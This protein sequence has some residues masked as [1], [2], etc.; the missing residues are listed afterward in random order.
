[1][2]RTMATSH[3]GL[4]FAAIL[5]V[6]L[7][8][9]TGLGSDG[10]ATKRVF[11]LNSYHAGFPWTNGI[12]KGIRSVLGEADEA[13]EV[14]VEYMD[15]KRYAPET[16]YP[17]LGEFY[18]RKYA[19]QHFDVIIT[20]DDNA[21][22]FLLERRKD[23]F[24]GVPVVFCAIN[25]PD[26]P[27]IASQPDITGV[28]EDWDA[29]GTIKVARRL[30]P[31]LKRFF[32]VSDITPT[33]R[34]HL[35]CLRRIEPEYKGSLK[36]VELAELSEADLREALSR[37]PDDSAVLLLSFYRDR[38][39][40]AF[41]IEE[42]VSLVAGSSP[43]PVYTMW[44]I[45]VCGGVLGGIVTSGRAQG[46]AAGRMAL[47][48]L[49]GTKADGIP[50]LRSSPNVP[51]FDYAAMRRFGIAQSVL[52]PGSVII[53]KPFSFY[54][55]YNRLVWGVLG[56]FTVLVVFILV[57]MLNIAKR[58]R[59]ETALRKSENRLRTVFE[60]AET[61]AFITTDLEAPHYHITDFS[62][63]AERIFGYSRDEIVGREMALLHLGEDVAR[64]PKTIEA[65]RE[66]AT[67][68]SGETTLVRKS[69]EKFPAFLTV[70]PV[71]ND[72]GEMTGIL[73]VSI[74]ITERK[75][76]EAER[77]ALKAQ[78]RY[79]QKLESLGVM[80]GGIA[81]DFNNFLTGILCNA[82]LALGNIPDSSPVRTYVQEVKK[83][84]IRASQL[85]GEMLAYS[86]KGSFDLRP[87]DLNNLV[88]EMGHLLEVSIS[89]RVVL[90]Y[91]LA[92]DL[93]A[94]LAD[95][96]QIRQV[97]MNLITNAAEAICEGIGTVTIRTGVTFVD[98]QPLSSYYTKEPLPKGNY[99][100]LEVSDNGCGMSA[101]TLERLFDPFY[102]T[103]F[104][105]RGLGLAAVLGIVRGHHGAITVESELAKG[106]TFRVLLPIGDAPATLQVPG[107]DAGSNWRGSGKVL[108]ADDEELVR[109]VATAMLEHM[110]FEVLTASN[111]AEA[112]E[113]CT[114]HG[115]E[116]SLILLDMTMPRMNGEEVFKRIR[117]VRSDLKV[118][119]TSGYTEQAAADRFTG[120]APAGFIHKPFDLKELRE[121][122]RE[123]LAS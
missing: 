44:D 109:N 20:S 16:V 80:A 29:R 50:V 54:A 112:V 4:L 121:K 12:T 65:L 64:F 107:E 71:I 96:V 43:Q 10:D 91:D 42:G 111:G 9:A 53:N 89:G 118:I 19:G 63:G 38:A 74:D 68:R 22:F 115:G 108:V 55:Q 114:R 59:A 85:I 45:A 86:G 52:P 113:I 105:G 110:G 77:N 100:Y 33:G 97:V 14:Y 2:N 83:T 28:A 6:V 99:I 60:T 46:E 7:L 30:Q 41:S 25:D 37:V 87:L 116:I 27:R 78:V 70:H 79:A 103:K 94:I 17:A 104:T 88:T 36:F 49:R 15:T 48:I 122:M 101:E 5:A 76:A 57:L 26:D 23:L 95:E 24:P 39:G 40:K 66:G 51:M 90:T 120:V 106:T 119:L 117:A 8:P 93:P 92:E 75:R 1:M 21:L 98:G 35:E 82:D 13:P 32:I 31:N 18:R 72:K 67:S 123:A 11:V 102:T 34:S 47:A 58:R 81:H 73:G 61:V 62:P 69:G 56:G 3:R 84:A